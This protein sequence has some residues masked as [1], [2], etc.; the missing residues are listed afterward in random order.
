MGLWKRRQAEA[1]RETAQLRTICVELGGGM[2]KGTTE[3]Q[4]LANLFESAEANRGN[5][6]G[7]GGEPAAEPTG[8]VA[9]A[10]KALWGVARTKMKALSAFGG[11]GGRR[12][13][14]GKLDIPLLAPQGGGVA[15]YNSIN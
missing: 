14:V 4:D 1:R 9:K 12:G 3:Q 7:N 6:N 11:V 15:S 5:V 10:G 13:G 8:A 2:R